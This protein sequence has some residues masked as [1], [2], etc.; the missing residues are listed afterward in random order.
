M[1]S[2]LYIYESHSLCEGGSEGKAA[3]WGGVG[4][5]LQSYCHTIVIFSQTP[6]G[7]PVSPGGPTFPCVPG[8][9]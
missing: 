1:L 8:K 2:Y 9:P 7:F 5:G 3:G 4:S 6:T